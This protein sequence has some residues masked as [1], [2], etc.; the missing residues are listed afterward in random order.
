[1]IAEMQVPFIDLK[2]G[3]A[4]L[5][6]DIVHDWEESLRSAEFIDGPKIQLL[7]SEMAKHL[8]VS[9]FVSCANGTDALQLG[10]RALGMGPGI[11][12][13]L[14]NLTFWAT[15]EAIANVGAKPLLIDI[16]PS[17][18]QMDLS[19]FKSAH[20]KHRFGAVVFVHL[21]GWTSGRLQEFRRFCKER[22]ILMLDDS[23]Q[24]FGVK[25]DNRSV[26][27][28]A[29]LSTL[30]FYPAKV[31]GGAMDGGGLATND[32]T[33]ADQVRTLRNHGR[34]QHYSY[35]A[36]GYNSR[37]SVLQS[38]FLLRVLGRANGFIESR[39]RGLEVY[40]TELSDAQSSFK[41]HLP[42]KGV[43]GNG[44]L[45]VVE[46]MKHSNEEVAQ[47]LKALGVG[48][49]RV[50]PETIDVQS[51]AQGAIHA[52]SLQKSKDFCKRVINLPLFAGITE[53]ECRYSAQGLLKA[54]SK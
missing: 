13:A 27:S 50:Y 25:V 54:V 2:R 33:L 26:F 43:T 5:E 49:G 10:L 12:V 14:P 30:S 19:E 35:S 17:D 24:A 16:D 53:E 44:Y 6:S 46:C 3:F 38:R 42:P 41:L 29:D 22:K 20:D 23:A 28:D 36:V 4:G 8:G 34:K 52:S 18:L 9:H 40:R 31:L 21:M 15:Y 32:S 48:T 11:T 1:M 7:E 45:A 37:M 47:K 51:P 39:L